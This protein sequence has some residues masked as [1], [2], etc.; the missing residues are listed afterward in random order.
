MRLDKKKRARLLLYNTYVCNFNH[1]IQI[2]IGEYMFWKCTLILTVFILNLY[3]NHNNSTV[4]LFY[5]QIY[6]HY[7][8]TLN[9]SFSRSL[10]ESKLCYL[11]CYF[12]YTK[13]NNNII[14]KCLY[15]ILLRFIQNL[16]LNNLCPIRSM[17][18]KL[19]LVDSSM[20]FTLTLKKYLKSKQN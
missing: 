12:F 13:K 10:T 4:D 19:P 2:C 15:G 18:S 6:L 7:F 16:F 9:W 3:L 11:K 5:L 1:K 17:S 8:L 14:F 20:Q